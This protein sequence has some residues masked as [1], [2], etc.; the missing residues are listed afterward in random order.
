MH[1]PANKPHHQWIMNLWPQYSVFRKILIVYL[2]LN[3]LNN[4]YAAWY[5]NKIFPG[6][7]SNKNTSNNERGYKVGRDGLLCLGG[8][9]RRVDRKQIRYKYI[10]KFTKEKIK[11]LF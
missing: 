3:V 10:V 4:L 7:A 5:I 9:N 2:S 1:R 6:R 8:G 11:V